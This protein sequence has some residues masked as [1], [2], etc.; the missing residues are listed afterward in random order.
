VYKFPSRRMW[1][2]SRAHLSVGEALQTRQPLKV[3]GALREACALAEVFHS[4]AVRGEPVLGSSPS[5]VPLN[6][7]AP[8]LG[9]AGSCGSLLSEA[10]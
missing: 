4:L 7:S 9:W 8:L 2:R 10:G 3:S 1:P 6:R 5:L